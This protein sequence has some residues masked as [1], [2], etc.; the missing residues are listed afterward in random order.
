MNVELRGDVGE[1]EGLVCTDVDAAQVWK[2]TL[3]VVVVVVAL[4]E[5]VA[6]M[7]VGWGDQLTVGA[8]TS[9]FVGLKA[10]MQF[11]YYIEGQKKELTSI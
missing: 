4:G 11:K 10:K 5:V 1:L 6:Q 7:C 2:R 3:V 9:P 8:H